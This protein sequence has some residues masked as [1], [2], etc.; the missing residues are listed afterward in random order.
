M[1]KTKSPLKERVTEAINFEQEAQTSPHFD[2]SIA[3]PLPRQKKWD[4]KKSQGL[5]LA[6]R[7]GSKEE[8]IKYFIEAL[9]MMLN[10]SVSP[11]DTYEIFDPDYI[12]IVKQSIQE[13]GSLF[14]W[15][16]HNR[17]R[18]LVF[19]QKMDVPW[20]TP[21]ATIDYHLQSMTRESICISI[22]GEEE[23]IMLL[24]EAIKAQHTLHQIHD[25][26]KGKLEHDD[27][28]DYEW[29]RIFPATGEDCPDI[30]I[31]SN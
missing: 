12:N 17:K 5:N 30:F 11:E 22:S 7:R 3:I 14:I 13:N 31:L 19:H 6:L 20:I 18:L 26:I 4:H 1:P 15:L 2:F 10:E 24:M 23:D 27:R 28:I 8:K 29:M 9:Q 21:A 16:G 25:R